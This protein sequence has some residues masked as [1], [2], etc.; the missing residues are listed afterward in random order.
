MKVVFFSFLMIFLDRAFPINAWKFAPKEF[1]GELKDIYERYGLVRFPRT[2]FA[3]LT[4]AALGAD[5]FIPVDQRVQG[6]VFLAFLVL[7]LVFAAIDVW[8]SRKR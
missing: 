1:D 3:V 6:G 4:C 7:F 8:K 2:L 5:I